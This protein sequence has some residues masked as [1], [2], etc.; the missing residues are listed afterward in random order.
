V[1]W[2]DGQVRDMSARGRVVRD[3]SGKPV[4]MLGAVADVTERHAAEEALRR[5][6][7][8]LTAIIETQRE[9]ATRDLEESAL[10]ELVLSRA[11]ELCGGASA[12]LSRLEP[13]GLRYVRVVGH[14]DEATGALVPID[15][16]FAGLA[17]TGDAPLLCADVASDDR[18]WAS[19]AHSFGVGSII[20]VPLHVES[21]IFGA[22][23]VASP[24]RG[25]FGDAELR[26]LELLAGFIGVAVTR[27]AAARASQKAAEAQS[28][29]AAIVDASSDPIISRRLDGIIESWN[30]AAERL[31]GYS[32]A[33]V[34]GTSLP[35][36]VPADRAESF[37]EGLARL[38]AGV[39]LDFE[40]VRTTRD[41]RRIDLAM[42]AAGIRDQAGKVVAAAAIFRDI[43]EAKA[44]DR[45][46]R[47]SL[48][49]KEVLLQ[50][51]HHR[52]KNNLQIIC[53]LLNLQSRQVTDEAALEAFRESQGRV[54]LMA[55]FHEKLYRSRDLGRVDLGDYLRELTATAFQ[56]WGAAGAR[57]FE[58]QADDISIGA[59]TAIPCGLILNELVSNSLKH[60]FKGERGGSVRIELR[61]AGPHK[62][63][64]T[65]RDDGRGFPADFDARRRKSL[66]LKLV[67][68]LT[69][70][71]G[72]TVSIESGP[73]AAFRIEFP[74]VDA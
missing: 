24:R 23:T 17:V 68:T 4:R 34:V 1:I 62:A 11:N 56:A 10:I 22:L 54:R 45:A 46:L 43:T 39:P 7:S 37:Q 20:A 33:E 50:E 30:P 9:V 66:G 49:E 3:A 58:V 35:G 13:G 12:S 29:L 48:Q 70:Q 47:A 27:T 36:W 26:A 25:A 72:G 16:T 44:Q 59:D 32:A 6:V 41:G 65:L 55:L 61:R 38:S 8:R 2:P 74:I 53:S 64:L 21:R 52:V 5:D 40:T 42:S 19:F 14:G 51:V 69:A 15:T 73:G 18:P 57:R 31:F 28:R 71:I 63:A 60:A 67:D